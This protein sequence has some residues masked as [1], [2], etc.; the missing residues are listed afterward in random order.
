MKHWETKLPCI[1]KMT[2]S[3]NYIKTLGIFF[4]IYFCGETGRGIYLER[5][6]R[7]NLS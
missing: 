3:K 2:T 6:Q 5:V 7:M 1:T 4:L